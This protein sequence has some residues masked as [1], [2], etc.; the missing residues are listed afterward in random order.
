MEHKLLSLDNFPRPVC[1]G[2]ESVVTLS[3]CLVTIRNEQHLNIPQPFRGVSFLWAKK[4]Q[5]FINQAQAQSGLWSC[6]VVS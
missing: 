2:E 4:E 5:T 1:H 6:L 3:H